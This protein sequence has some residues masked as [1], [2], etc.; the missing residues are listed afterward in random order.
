[1]TSA[2]PTKGG[3][4]AEPRSGR[5][6]PFLLIVG[7]FFVA[8]LVVFLSALLVPALEARDWATAKAVAPLMPAVVAGA[9][10]VLLFLARRTKTLP[11]LFVAFL[12]AAFISRLIAPAVPSLWL[13]ELAGAPAKRTPGPATSA[14]A[15]P[16]DRVE[17]LGEIIVGTEKVR[18]IIVQRH[19][20]PNGE[21]PLETSSYSATLTSAVTGVE[22]V[23]ITV[24]QGENAGSVAALLED[25]RDAER[26]YLVGP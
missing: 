12:A 5:W 8:L 17:A 4:A 16:G 25:L 24:Q 11:E 15:L 3:A 1:M 6:T 13:D 26:I 21:R 2:E 7:V 18:V 22:D 20:G 10:L 14:V 19:L 9:A 23:L